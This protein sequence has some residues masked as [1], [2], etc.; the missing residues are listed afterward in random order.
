M[1]LPN[2]TFLQDGKY[3]I[4]R[5]ISNGGFGCTY[6]AEHVLL[7]KRMAVK[8][9]FV[10]DFCNRD[11]TTAHITVGTL[12]K[13]GLVEKLRKKFFDEAKAVCKLEHK[14]IVRVSDVFEE[15]GT[16]YYVMDYIKGLSLGDIVKQKGAISE[17]KAV[18]YIRQVAEALDYVHKHNRLH[19]DV[20]PGNIMVDEHDN[21]ILIDFGASKQ[22]DEVNGENTSTLM[23]KTP[24]YAPPEQM[25]NDVTKFTPAT[26]IYALGATFYKLLT[27]VTPLSVELIL[28]GEELVPLPKGTSENVRN[29]IS[30]SMQTIKTKRPQNIKEFLSI[31]NVGEEDEID[32][33]IVDAGPSKQKHTSEKDKTN[34]KDNA[35][36]EATNNDKGRRNRTPLFIFFATA[37]CLIAVVI[38]LF[39]WKPW[40]D[41][42]SEWEIMD[43]LE[44]MQQI[45]QTKEVTYDGVT[46][47]YTGPVNDKGNPEGKGKGVY[48]AGTYEGEYVDGCREG[49]GTFESSNG[50]NSFDGTF[51]NNKYERG[52]LTFNDDGSY[53]IGTFK[54]GKPYTGVLYEKDGSVYCGYKNGKMVE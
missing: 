16:A 23:G 31:L 26:D 48:P 32:V 3:K 13:K 9:F 41:N 14:G 28:S 10:K 5:F 29:V 8:E 39:I 2:G 21:A 12:S 54:D 52:T 6:E 46:F 25:G 50:N 53:F 24:G 51:K 17:Q 22:Y 4:V 1:H 44:E 27:G 45:T 43:K 35:K 37:V 7:E 18:K 40:K 30:A 34:D 33:T 19:L 38:I 36:K 42:S 15:N 20:K 49:K 47:T 11:E